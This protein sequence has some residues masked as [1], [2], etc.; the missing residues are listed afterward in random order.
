MSFK[1]CRESITVALLVAGLALVA[2]VWLL[3]SP[4]HV[5]ALAVLLI[6]NLSVTI[7]NRRRRTRGGVGTD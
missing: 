4:W 1:Y 3:P 7:Y 6:A 5:I 2:G